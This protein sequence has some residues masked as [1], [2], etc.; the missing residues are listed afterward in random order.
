MYDVK[1]EG[2]AFVAIWY[3]FYR[4]IGGRS[5]ASATDKVQTLNILGELFDM[6]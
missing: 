2:K 4:V 3:M 1:K 6:V 5:F